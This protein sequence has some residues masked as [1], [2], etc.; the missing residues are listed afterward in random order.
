M[1]IHFAL[2]LLIFL[3][4]ASLSAAERRTD[5]PPGSEYGPFPTF[6]GEAQIGLHF[7]AMLDTENS[8]DSSFS[9]GADLDYRPFALFGFRATY[10]QSIQKPRTSLISLTPLLHT[11]ISNF[12]PYVSFGP[13]VAIIN[14]TDTEAKFA[15][16][17]GIGGDFLMT[18]NLGLGL[19]YV[20]AAL[21]DAIDL[22]QVGA[23]VFYSFN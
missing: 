20:Y 4:G 17:G 12:R 14:R 23:R 8:D 11:E 2:S 21:F 1:R 5:G 7:G 19:E 10:L 6:D 3:C 22:H 18:D 15:I 13:G 16:T 9:L